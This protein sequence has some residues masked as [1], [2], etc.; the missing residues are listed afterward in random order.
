M[1]ESV[2]YEIIKNEGI[3]E[4]VQQGLQHGLQQGVQQG[5]Q[6]GLREAVESLLRVKFGVEGTKLM[7]RLNEDETVA[8]LR[9]IK[10]TIEVAQNIKEFEEMFD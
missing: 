1:I 9:A 3:K 5:L 6:Q 4:G 10:N 7:E 8:K 2:A